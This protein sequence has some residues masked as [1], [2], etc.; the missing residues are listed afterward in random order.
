MVYDIE[1]KFTDDGGNTYKYYF[2]THFKLNLE[3]VNR[4]IEVSESTIIKHKK[5][6]INIIKDL[7]KHHLITTNSE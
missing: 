1:I 4:S 3:S 7:F 5:E 2:G 6:I